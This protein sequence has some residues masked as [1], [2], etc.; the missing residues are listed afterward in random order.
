MKVR[1]GAVIFK[2]SDLRVPLAEGDIVPCPNCSAKHFVKRDPRPGTRIDTEMGSVDACRNE[3]LYV[4]CPQAI[5][6][7]VVGMDGYVLPQP[8]ELTPRKRSV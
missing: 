1:K 6:P 8:L 4:E 2:T 7:I 3:A 5:G